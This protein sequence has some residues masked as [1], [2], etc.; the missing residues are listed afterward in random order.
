MPV[1]VA[2]V[3]LSVMRAQLSTTP[4][5]QAADGRIDSRRLLAGDLNGRV[6][7]LGPR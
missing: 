1:E 5:Q 7:F 6:E 2:G 4:S 3:R